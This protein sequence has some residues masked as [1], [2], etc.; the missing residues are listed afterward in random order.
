MGGPYCIRLGN[1]IKSR[2]A[3]IDSTISV[4][5]RLKDASKCVFIHLNLF[6]GCK[7]TFLEACWK[8]KFRNKYNGIELENELGLEWYGYKA[9]IMTLNR[10]DGLILTR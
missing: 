10:E 6:R 1:A 5:W 7:Y 2:M 3:T 8:S 4:S 9:G